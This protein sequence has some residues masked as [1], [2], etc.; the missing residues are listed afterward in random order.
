MVLTFAAALALVPVKVVTPTFAFTFLGI[1]FVAV[2]FTA[3]VFAV[4]VVVTVPRLALV[5][6]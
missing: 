6:S 4:A 2:V 5:K 1:P 3:T